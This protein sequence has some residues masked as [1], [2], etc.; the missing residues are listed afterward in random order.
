MASEAQILE[1]VTEHLGEIQSKL[2]NFDINFKPFT[3]RSLANFNR[4]DLKTR[5]GLVQILSSVTRLLNSA[6]KLSTPENLDVHLIQEICQELD[7]EVPTDFI[8]LLQP[9]DIIEIYNGPEKIQVFRNFT[10]LKYC[11][12]DL[13]TLLSTP[14]PELY[15]R[16]ERFGSLITEISEEVWRT[17]TEARKWQIEDHIIYEKQGASNLR[18]KMNL[19]HVGPVFRKD[20]SRFGWI[21]SIQVMPLGSA[22]DD[23]EMWCRSTLAS[24]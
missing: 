18:F 3:S 4:F 8:Q 14:Y 17:A 22:Y 16:E 2:S 21:S 11:S 13:L 6:P 1:Q 23:Q 15:W 9:N 19:K 7:L 20:G 10:F 12:Y 24:L 5:I